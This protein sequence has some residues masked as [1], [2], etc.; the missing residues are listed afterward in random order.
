MLSEVAASRNT[1]SI[2]IKELLLD[3]DGILREL[4][5]LLAAYVTTRQPGA[6]FGDFVVRMEAVAA[7]RFGLDFHA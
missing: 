1:K 5:P 3:E 7:T 4:A 2:E 6:G